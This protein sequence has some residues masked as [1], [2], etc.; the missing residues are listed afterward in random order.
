MKPATPAS[1]SRGGASPWP[2]LL[3]RL[4]QQRPALR[5]ELVEHLVLGVEVVVD[6]PVGD[7]GLVRDVGDAGAV[8]ALP[9]EDRDRGVEDRAALVGGRGLGHHDAPLA[10]AGSGAEA[11]TPFDWPFSGQR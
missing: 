1:L 2:H 6:E 11:C 10:P 8:E 4:D 3:D 9:G 7:A 5:E